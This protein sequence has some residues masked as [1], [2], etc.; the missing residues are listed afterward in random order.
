METLVELLD[1]LDE[2]LET[3]KPVPFSSKVS[4]DKEQVFELI[5]E[6]RMNLPNEL[7]QAQ[8]VLDDHEK[9]IQD[10]KNKA[11]AILKEADALALDRAG[12]H[13]VYQ[14]ASEQAR[15]LHDDTSKAARAMQ[16]ETI[17]YV[18]SILSKTEES[19]R[20]ALARLAQHYRNI[21]EEFNVTMDILYSNRQ[22]IQSADS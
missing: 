12:A 16:N 19:I 15:K 13:E 6:I 20:E 18:D 2:L 1:E 4:I 5:A 17:A 14:L 7:R 9:I 11:V 10:A 8:R 22:E 3:S 21:E